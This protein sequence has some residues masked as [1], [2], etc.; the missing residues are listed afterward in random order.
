[1]KHLGFLEFGP[2][3]TYALN[4]DMG[5]DVYYQLKPTFMT[6]IYTNDLDDGGYAGAGLTHA[7]GVGFRYKAFALALEPNFGRMKVIDIDSSDLESKVNTSNFKIKLGF[8]F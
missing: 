6:G 8:K 2:S 7:A 4:D 5:L 3:F 1:M